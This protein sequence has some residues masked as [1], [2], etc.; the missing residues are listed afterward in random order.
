[1]LRHIDGFDQFQGQSSQ[2]LLTSLQAAG[3]AA[4]NGIAMADGRKAGTHALE[5]QVA[6]GTGGASWSARTN[7]IKADLYGVAANSQG[8]FVAVGEGGVATTSTDGINW[9]ALVLGTN[10]NMRAIECNEGTYIA[11][12]D[13][14]AILRSIDGQVWSVRTPPTAGLN[15][16]DVACS[17]DRWLAVGS[18]GNAGAIIVSDDDGM[19]WANVVENPGAVG[20]LCVEYGDCWMVGG[21][22]G[23]VLT[24]DTGLAF[25]S[26]PY[27]INTSVNDVAF[28]NGTWLA[29]HDGSIRR[30]IDKGVSWA[31]AAAE[32]IANSAFRT[33]K[34]SDGRWIV[35]GDFAQL[36]MSD[37]TATWT[38]PAIAGAA[39]LTIFDINTSSG[40]QI[41]WCLVGSRSGQVNSTA[42]IYVS[43]APPTT[44]T[45]TLVSTQSRVVIGFA[46]RAT[47]RGRIFSIKDVLNLDWPAGVEI[48]GV[49]GAS[50]P[51]RNTWYYYEIEI[52]K[53]AKKVRLFVNDTLDLTADLPDA[54]AAVTTYLMTW[55][56]ENGAVARIDD[57]YLL[58]SDITGGSTLTSRLKPISVPLRMPTEDVNVNWDGSDPGPH[59]T[60]VG[61]LPPSAASFVRSATSGEQDLYASDTPLP[62]GA[63]T[64]TMPIIAVG[65]IALA[66][67]SDLDN[68]QLGL[69]IGDVGNQSEVIDTSLST[70]LE[71]SFGIF[72]KAPGDQPWTAENV[73]STPF[74]VAVR[75]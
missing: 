30:S 17:G 58:D 54:A 60:L 29:I 14:G 72:E 53:A 43:L 12:G 34:V 71:Y 44:L 73:E 75:P 63:G 49:R 23:Q 7:T 40:A 24:S 35:G 56:A 70:T 26:R 52:D 67:K 3:Y 32:L 31:T 69:V 8:R 22:N 5:L 16:A 21:R 9:A 4:S 25:T 27:G 45:R 15:L 48:L 59:W 46:H 65:V 64:E 1:M 50:V 20:N 38:K 36:Y 6:A 51:I 28:Y 13:N 33:I 55:Q 62:A 47:A 68:R 41:G 74:G 2:S 18:N 37:D 57:V 11:V 61:L 66:Q 42:L 19:T 39:P 10:K